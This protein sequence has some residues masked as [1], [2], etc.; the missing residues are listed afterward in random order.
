MPPVLSEDDQ[1]IITEL[2]RGWR[3]EMESIAA[4][5]RRDLQALRQR[6]SRPPGVSL[7]HAA[8]DGANVAS[9]GQRFV[10]SGELKALLA[11]PG[12]RGR[13][14]A[15]VGSLFE[16]KQILTSDGAVPPTVR[17]P[18]IVPQPR[19]SLRLRDLISVR[20][21]DAV[22][23]GSVDYLRQK[24][25]TTAAAPQKLEGDVK[26]E[27]Q[28]QTD[29]VTAKFSTVAC[30]TAASRQALMDVT[31]LQ[32]FI[33]QEL[34]YQTQLEEEN[35]ILNG[36]GAVNGQLDGL[37]PAATPY[38]AAL[39]P[40]NGTMLDVLAMAEAQLL[41]AD[42]VPSGLI[43]NSMDMA[44]IELLMELAPVMTTPGASS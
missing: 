26:A 32:V 13:A 31:L 3:E 8:L 1:Q 33:D 44:R 14:I 17:L 38:N 2:R 4:P 11:S 5:L 42:V 7:E 41:A 15:T 22:Q 40:P 20:P 37:L 30:W 36:T 21:F 34:V 25:R 18:G 23:A 27:I 19:R 12:Q 10:D 43:L 35:G 9:V 29:L 39:T 6:A 16:R 28:I 24:P